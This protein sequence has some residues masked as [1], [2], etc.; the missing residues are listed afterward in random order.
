MSRAVRLNRTQATSGGDMVEKRSRSR[1]PTAQADGA[2]QR[3]NYNLLF[4]PH[5]A[6]QRATHTNASFGAGSRTRARLAV[7]APEPTVGEEPDRHSTSDASE[8]PHRDHSAAP[9]GAATTVDGKERNQQ[10]Q[11]RGGGHPKMRSL[12]MEPNQRTLMRRV[13]SNLKTN[14]PKRRWQMALEKQDDT[15]EEYLVK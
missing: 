2:P 3:A 11:Q 6:K 7:S 12:A 1:S 10:Q 15:A 9:A 5:F 14:R 13:V 8:R 4:N